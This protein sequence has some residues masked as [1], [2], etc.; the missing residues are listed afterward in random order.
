MNGT[1]V[2]VDRNGN[3][4]KGPQAIKKLEQ[5]KQVLLKRATNL[6]AAKNKLYSNM[7]ITKPM[8]IHE[9]KLNKTIANIYGNINKIVSEKRRIAR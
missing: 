6:T 4:E 9:K 1:H 3:V 7:D 2:F 5:R 8:A